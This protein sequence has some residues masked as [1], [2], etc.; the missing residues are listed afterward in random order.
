MSDATDR[1]SALEKLVTL[2]QP[3]TE[4]EIT[5]PELEEILDNNKRAQRWTLN[6]ALTLGTRV[7]PNIRMGRIY[8]VTTEGT[9]GATEPSWTDEYG[10]EVTSG[11]ATFTEVGV[12]FGNVY[13]VRAA[14]QEC[15]RL[16]RSK[17][18]ELHEG[19][20]KAIFEHAN[21]VAKSLSIPLIA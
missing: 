8:E 21:E 1:D 14:A 18:I 3:D 20:E 11:T 19:D 16:R 15:A 2:V 4:P 6:T 9:T 7:M 5:E 12:D 13:D 17:A 10:A